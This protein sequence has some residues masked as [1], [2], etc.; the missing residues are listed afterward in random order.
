MFSLNVSG[1]VDTFG[2]THQA[3]LHL[4]EFVKHSLIA[5]LAL[6][7]ICGLVLIFACSVSVFCLSQ[8]RLSWDGVSYSNE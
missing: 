6:S 2:V 7:G 4:L 5:E 8:L 1:S 3:A